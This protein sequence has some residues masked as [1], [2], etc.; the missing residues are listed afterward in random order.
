[1]RFLELKA[2]PPTKAAEVPMTRFVLSL[3]LAFTVSCGDDEDLC[4]SDDECADN[5]ACA[6]ATGEEGVDDEGCY[7]RCE[8]DDDCAAGATCDSDGECDAGIID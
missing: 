6:G 1:V 2:K 7:E 3:V 4:E 5:F 8:G